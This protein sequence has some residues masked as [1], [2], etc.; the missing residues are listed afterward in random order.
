MFPLPKSFLVKSTIGV[1]PYMI[2]NA[3]RVE[4]TNYHSDFGKLDYLWRT[5]IH[6]GQGKDKARVYAPRITIRTIP[7][8]YRDV[9]QTFIKETKSKV[10]NMNKFQKIFCM[11]TEQRK[12]Q[13]YYGPFELLDSIKDFIDT[14]FSAE[15]L[16]E[17][18][19]VS[20]SPYEIPFGIAVGYVILIRVVTGKGR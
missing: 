6:Y 17:Y 10:P 11:T 13:R 14:T 12:R 3:Y 19:R 2:I 20:D 18:V 15:E 5:E 8:K 16:K 1:Y 4:L 7:I 9:V